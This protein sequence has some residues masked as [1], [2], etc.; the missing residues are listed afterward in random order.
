M[1][2]RYVFQGVP[3][4][5]RVTESYEVTRPLSR[6]GWFVSSVCSGAATGEGISLAEWSRPSVGWRRWLRV[7]SAQARDAGVLDEITHL[8]TPSMVVVNLRLSVAD[9]LRRLP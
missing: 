3:G 8:V 5:T 1:T 4:G 9:S 7:T 2:W 6:L